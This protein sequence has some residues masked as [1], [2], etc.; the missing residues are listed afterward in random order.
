MG[1]NPKLD[2]FNFGQGKSIYIALS[3]VRPCCATICAD[4]AIS[5]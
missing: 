5:A 4:F 3:V 2:F 1:I